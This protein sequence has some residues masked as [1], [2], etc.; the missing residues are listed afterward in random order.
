[1]LTSGAAYYSDDHANAYSMVIVPDKWPEGKEREVCLFPFS[2]ST[3][4]GWHENKWMNLPAGHNLITLAQPDFNCRSNFELILSYDDQNM[5]IPLKC[6]SVFIQED[7]TAMLNNL[8][9]VCRNLDITCS[10]HTDKPGTSNISIEIA[11]TKESSVE[12]LLTRET[13]FS[14]LNHA[15]NAQNRSSFKLVDAAGNVFLSGKNINCNEEIEEDGIEFLKKLRKIEL[16]YDLLF[17]CPEDN[18]EYMKVDVL[19]ELIELG[20]TTA[21]KAISELETYSIDKKQLLKIGLHSLKNRPLY[22]LHRGYFRCQLYGNDFSLGNITVLMGPY[23]TKGSGTI[24]KAMT[25]AK[26]DKRK[27]NLRLCDN[28]ICYLITDEKKAD[29]SG[30]PNDLGEYIQVDNMDCVWDF[31]YEIHS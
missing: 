10:G 27:I 28:S 26:G 3:E 1:M 16:K 24:H 6:V 14:F 5:S 30:L 15:T 4:N 19:S 25:Y 8:E 2:Y 11:S 22:I 9:D 20:Y 17:Q 13:V 7:N 18:A 29:I 21:F 23:T 12:A 31:I